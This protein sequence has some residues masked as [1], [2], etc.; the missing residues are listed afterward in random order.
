MLQRDAAPA[1]GRPGTRTAGQVA[2][3][4]APIVV[5]SGAAGIGKT[6]LA[7]RFGRQVAKRFPDGQL[8]VNLRGLDPARPAM[9]PWEVLRFFLDSLGVAPYRIPPEPRAARPCTAARWTAGGC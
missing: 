8:Y 6:A 5:I 2:G 1:R 3:D 4:S 7:I 9:E